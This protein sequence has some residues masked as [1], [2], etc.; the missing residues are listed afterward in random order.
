MQ[1]RDSFADIAKRHM[2]G[3]AGIEPTTSASRK[4]RSTKLSY[5][6]N[7]APVGNR[8]QPSAYL[9]FISGV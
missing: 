9:T 4:Q 1:H 2:V 8:T 5:I 7:G 3:I 6:P